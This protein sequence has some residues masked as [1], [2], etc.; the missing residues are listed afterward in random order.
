[1]RVKT[2]MAQDAIFKAIQRQRQKS[3]LR[4]FIENPMK[5]FEEK[6]YLVY[7]IA[8][9]LSTIFAATL[10][11]LHVEISDVIIF[12]LI[13]AFIPPGLYD[14]HK[15]GKIR[16]MEAEFPALIRDISLSVESG[17]TLQAALSLTAQGE[18]GALNPVIKHLANL[19]SWGV[20][21]EEALLY[22]ARKYPTPLIKR[23][24][25][26]IIEASKSGG[27]TGPILKTVAIDCEETKGLEKR[28]SAETQPYLMV[29]YMAFFVFMAVIIM[30]SRSFIGMMAQIVAETTVGEVGGIRFRVSPE[31]IAMYKT[32]FFHALIVQGIFAGLV[33]GKIG[34]GTILAG[35]KHSLIFIVISIIAYRLIA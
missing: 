16:K 13:L 21:F 25:A 3:T 24:V 17:M 1:M 32:L 9:I 28:R 29:G 11:Y 30:V 10:L 35:I 20:S 19:V 7:V 31:D 8:G 14:F 33:T 12:A 6:P 5:A 4:R 2:H 23:T 34:E 15:R 18:Y 22:L 27:E 26:T